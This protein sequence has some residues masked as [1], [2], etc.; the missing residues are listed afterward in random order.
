VLSDASR[1]R[2]NEAP[3]ALRRLLDVVVVVVALTPIVVLA[4]LAVLFLLIPVLPDSWTDSWVQF[5]T[6]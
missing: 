4:G 5:P 2:G 1:R 6:P 3:R